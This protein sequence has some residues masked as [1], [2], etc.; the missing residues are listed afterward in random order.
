MK[1]IE[2]TL[3]DII[4][5]RPHPFTL[6]ERL[7]YIYPVTLAKIF[8]LHRQIESLGIDRQLLEND[9]Y[10]EAMRLVLQNKDACC[11]ILAY[12]TSPNTYNDLFDIQ[13]WQERK[14]FFMCELE[15]EDM[16]S[17]LINVLTA[18]K[19]DDYIKDLGLDK[20][21]QRLEAVM[22]IK[23]EKGGG[24]SIA[25]NG[26]SVMGAFILPLMEIGFTDNQILYE[27]SYTYLRLLLADKVTSIYLTEEE[28]QSVST[29]FGGDL[30][31]ANK[32]GSFK[33]IS[34]LMEKR[35]IKVNKK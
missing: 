17:L 5:A 6:G 30:P 32:P 16:A 14:D 4:I 28:A 21:R 34:A 31:D 27:K 20:E 23:E 13:A 24:K 18:D 3:A 29:S 7:F 12:H 25:F 33:T 15:N 2:H 19:T 26:T 11:Q 9:P 10:M 22:K 8:L 35:G 1:A